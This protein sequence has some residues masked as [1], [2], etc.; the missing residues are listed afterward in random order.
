MKNTP[1]QN[2]LLNHAEKNP[3]S[4][5]MP[6]HKGSEIFKKYG[7]TEFLEKF[8][9]CDITEI[10]GADNLFQTEGILEEAQKKYTELYEVKKSYL[11]INGT[12]GGIIASILATVPKG[13]KL[14]MARNCHKS[15]FNALTLGDLQPVYAYPEMVENYGISGEIPAEEIERLLSENHDV[16]AVI[17]PS[18]NYYGICSDIEKIA[19]IVHKYGK[20][21]IVDQAHGAHLK[22]FSKFGIK[23]LPKSAE[24]S[25]ADIVINSIH[26]TLASLTQSAVLNLN[27]NR[28]EPLILEDKLQ[29]IESTSPSYVLMAMLD[30]NASI[31]KDQGKELFEAWGRNLEDF[32]ERVK[33]IPAL[34][35]I[36]EIDNLDWTKIN[37]SFGEIGLMGD[38]LE[39][40][41]SH[42]Y[43]IFIELHTADLVMCMTG[44]GN[45][46]EDLETLA[47]AL[48]EIAAGK[49]END[50]NIL[51]EALNNK[52]EKSATPMLKAE[53]CPVPRNKKKVK[54]VDAEGEICASS[55]IPY[56]PG[57]P[58]LCPGERIT[59]EAIDYVK[60]LR[61]RG[62]KVIGVSKEYE[63]LV[64]DN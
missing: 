56:P 2:F 5:H 39:E 15:V 4:F 41:L 58:F 24:E 40:I 35:L 16:E 55:L 52:V 29:A 13:K 21:L 61:D 44:I 63:I 17:L 49:K 23:G 48:E 43:G 51:N 38:E 7:Y 26:K 22:F 8:V 19:E 47:K 18:P 20:V 14:L 32:Y 1:I 31:I 9:D 12:S 30:I 34:K 6:G 50:T 57:I 10:P 62:E 42:K 11:Q 27:S 59:Q 37:F 46:R 3:I 60:E 45:S 25:G 64:G 28:V 53:L 54:L 36:R 33:K